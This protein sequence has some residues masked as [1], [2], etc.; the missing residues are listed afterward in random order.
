MLACSCS[1]NFCVAHKLAKQFFLF[2]LVLTKKSQCS[3]CSRMLAKTIRHPLIRLMSGCD[4]VVEAQ[5]CFPDA[6]TLTILSF[7]NDT[8]HLNIFLSQFPSDNE[9]FFLALQ[10]IYQSCFRR[11]IIVTLLTK[12][13]ST[14]STQPCNSQHVP[15]F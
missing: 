8:V 5:A 15:R 12:I 7:F 1:P 11:R 6:L 4:M 14:L 3:A 13:Q 10:I 2:L 9:N